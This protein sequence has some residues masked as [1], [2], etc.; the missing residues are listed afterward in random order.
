[1]STGQDIFVEV[2]DAG[3]VFNQYTHQLANIVGNT[4]AATIAMIC[5]VDA[6]QAQSIQQVSNFLHNVSHLLNSL[7]LG[8]LD[9][10]SCKSVNPIYTTF[11][12][13][14]KNCAVYTILKVLPEYHLLKFRTFKISVVWWRCTWPHL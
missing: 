13:D 7:L 8:L 2:L 12:Y 5:G 9:L 6:A 3:R 10:L 1:M 14:G 11:I 4:D